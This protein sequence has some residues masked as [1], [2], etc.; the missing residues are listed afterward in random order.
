MTM[1][2]RREFCK[3]L[4]L[5]SSIAPFTVPGRACADTQPAHIPTLLWVSRGSDEAQID[6]STAEGYRAIAWMLRD[7]RAGVIGVPHGRLLEQWSWM[8]AWLAAYGYHVRFDIHSGLR[9]PATNHST[10]GAALASYHLPNDQGVFRAG[11]FSTP[12]I[13]SEYM[14]RLAWLSQQGGVGFYTRDFIHT[15]VRGLPVSWRAR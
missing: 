7:V 13:P 15:D 4:A 2:G 1:I 6:Y 11:D 14:G 10:E 8:Q 3:A 9:T 5:A 12:T